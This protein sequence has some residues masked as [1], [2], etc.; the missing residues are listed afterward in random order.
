MFQFNDIAIEDVIVHHIGSKTE[1]E[2]IQLSN[3]GLDLNDDQLQ[4]LLMQYFLTPF[5]PGEMFT[6]THPEDINKNEVY[7]C[8]SQIFADRETFIEQSVNLANH[9]YEQSEHPKINPGELYVAYF[10]NCMVDGDMVDAIGLFKSESKETFLKV[11]NKKN[12]LGVQYHSGVNINKLDKGC[13]IFNLEPEKGYQVIIVDNVNKG[14]EAQFWKDR[15]LQ[16]TT[17][18]DEYH[19]TRNYLDMC[20][21]FVMEEAPREFEISKTDQTEFMN[22]SANYF[23]KNEDFNYQDFAEQVIVQPEV[24]E[25]FNNYKKQYATEHA[26]DITDEFAISAPAVKK[27][28]KTMKNVIKLDKNFHIYVH[29]NSEYL[30]KGFDE[31]TGM[32]FYQL[33]FKEEHN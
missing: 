32:H 10:T 18:K 16:V 2:G 6:L 19:Q 24:V 28:A 11:E 9:L 22:K 27:E 31:N 25:S 1:D 33:Y 29:G 14:G 13:L 5:K 4:V 26:C 23:K 8:I 21:T 15:F 7:A 20:K 12:S 17:R 3:L 30:I